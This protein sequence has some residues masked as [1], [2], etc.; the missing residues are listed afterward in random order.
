MGRLS[1]SGV[2][3]GHQ[4]V[5]CVGE[6]ERNHAHSAL[7]VAT[8]PGGSKKCFSREQNHLSSYRRLGLQPIGIV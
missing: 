4:G 1:R 5:G 7:L 3:P 2:A 8:L 6:P